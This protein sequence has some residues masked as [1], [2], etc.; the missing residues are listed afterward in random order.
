MAY[1]TYNRR[2]FIVK[3][4]K[5]TGPALWQ[6]IE[7]IV[8]ILN[9]GAMSSDHTDTEAPTRYKQLLRARTPWRATDVADL[10]ETLETYPS[11]RGPVGNKPYPRTSALHRAPMSV[12]KA[13]PKLPINFYDPYWYAARSEAEKAELAAGKAIK[14]PILYPH[15][16][17][18]VFR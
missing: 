8:E 11:G 2:V 16:S 14:I 9:V 4:N 1:Q 3:N 10:M 12:R 17:A 13:M 7:K 6:D 18:F 5:E 15:V